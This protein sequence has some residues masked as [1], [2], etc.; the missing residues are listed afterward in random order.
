[1]ANTI[2]S[3]EAL[4]QV[5]EHVFLPPK[6]PQQALP[7]THERQVELKLVQLVTNAVDQYRKL[8]SVDSDQWSRM[9]RMLSRVAQNVEAS[10]GKNQVEQD[11][12]NMAVG[13]MCDSFQIQ[14]RTN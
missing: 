14:C 12:A 9:S 10:L 4:L 5:A 2:S 3:A 13:G 11:M 6:L 7:D 1:M 8:V